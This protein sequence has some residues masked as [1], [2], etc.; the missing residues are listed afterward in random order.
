MRLS[1]RRLVEIARLPGLTN[2]QIGEDVI[3]GGIRGC[4]GEAPSILTADAQWAQVM[5]TTLADGKLTA[6]PVGRYTGPASLTRALT[7][8]N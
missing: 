8:A 1:G 2:H 3:R 5:A 7:C 4:A 6:K